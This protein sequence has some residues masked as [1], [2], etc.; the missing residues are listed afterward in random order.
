MKRLLIAV[1]VI[2]I[3]VFLHSLFHLLDWAVWGLGMSPT[4]LRASLLPFFQDVTPLGLTVHAGVNVAT[5]VAIGV[6]LATVVVQGR[7]E[8]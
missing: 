5:L 3:P 8:G 2:L 4:D 6:L 1:A 7:R